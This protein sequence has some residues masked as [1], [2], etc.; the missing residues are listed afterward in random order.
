MND[1]K[2]NKQIGHDYDHDHTHNPAHKLENEINSQNVNKQAQFHL[3]NL[4]I[5][6]K[7]NTFKLP[8][9]LI[10]IFAFI[11]LFSGVFQHFCGQQHCSDY[12]IG[13]YGT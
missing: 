11:E 5:K 7:Y 2:Q 10:L 6:N 4:S 3:K 13:R 12:F 9:F 8:F 1:D